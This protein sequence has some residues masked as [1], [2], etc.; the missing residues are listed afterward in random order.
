MASAAGFSEQLIFDMESGTVQRIE[1][2][3]HP[4]IAA[5]DVLD[6]TIK[7]ILETQ[8]PDK[9]YMTP[10]LPHGTVM[11]GVVGASHI[12]IIVIPAYRG[13]VTFDRT[14]ALVGRAQEFDEEEDAEETDDARHPQQG[15]NTPR[16]RQPVDTTTGR[17]AEL[18]L[19]VPPV[20]LR[21]SFGGSSLRVDAY[22]LKQ[23]TTRVT[24]ATPVYPTWMANTHHHSNNLCLGTALKPTHAH[25][26]AAYAALS[27]FVQGF[28]TVFFND[29]LHIPADRVPA[30]VAAMCAETR[31]ASDIYEGWATWTL[32]NQ[33]K[34]IWDIS[35]PTAPV[36]T[37]QQLAQ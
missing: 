5:S 34:R 10:M 2:R 18:V 4:P 9:K 29:D 1:T 26:T 3:A 19:D 28:H 22:F 13:P 21:T 8:V 14:N 7:R 15:P 23:G 24:P 27:E 37:L 11:E 35:W 31:Y 36:K 32:L 17:I 20:V 6:P 30:D 12:A 33:Q 25:I 16:Q